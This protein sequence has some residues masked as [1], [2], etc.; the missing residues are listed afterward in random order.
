MSITSMDNLWDPKETHI[1]T[2]K[3]YKQGCRS[4]L[5]IGGDL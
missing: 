5:D 1:Y 4:D 2:E 3:T